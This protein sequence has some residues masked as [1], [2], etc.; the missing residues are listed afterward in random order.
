MYVFRFRFCVALMILN[1]CCDD[2]CGAWSTTYPYNEST[3]EYF[4]ETANVG[5]Y[6]E[7]LE[8]EFCA[9]LLIQTS[10]L[11][12]FAFA[13]LFAQLFQLFFLPAFSPDNMRIS[14]LA[15]LKVLFLDIFR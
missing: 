14:W 9:F 7:T 5:M 8:T 13:S 15:H 6:W 4:A 12:V 10:W 11:F 3:E 1:L 2:L